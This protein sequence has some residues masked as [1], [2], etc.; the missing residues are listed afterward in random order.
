MRFYNLKKA[1]EDIDLASV[2]LECEVFEKEATN[3]VT[4]HH[5]FN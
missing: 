5:Y 4:I 1:T 2:K 3:E